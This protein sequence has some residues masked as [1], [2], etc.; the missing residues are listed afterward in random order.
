MS[1]TVTEAATLH[2][3]RVA[4][5]G[6]LATM[7]RAQVIRLVRERGGIWCPSVNRTTTMLVVG[8]EG[9]PLQADGR[10]TTKLQRARSLAKS[11][12]I[13]IVSEGCF[14][15]R[16]GVEAPGGA[17]RRVSLSTLSDLLKVPGQ[18]IR[19]WIE[20]GLVQP[21]ETVEGI[22]HFDFR[23]VSWARTLC[24]CL[25]AGVP[26]AKLRR[27]IEQLRDWLPD[28]DE[29]LTRLAVLEKDGRLMVR[30]QVGLVEPSGQRTLPFEEEEPGGP[31]TVPLAA[32]PQTASEWF[33]VG[34]E[35]E[36]AGD[37]VEAE[38]AYRQ[39]LALGDPEAR[40][41]FNLANVLYA[42]GQKPAAAERYRQAVEL[43]P[44]DADAW[45]NLG[46]VLE[47]LGEREEALAAYQRSLGINPHG[48]EALYNL[49]ELLEQMGR[50][51][52]A[53]GYLEN[54]LRHEPVGLYADYARCQ[55][56]AA[57]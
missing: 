23:Q 10:L 45:N 52:E 15:D 1:D 38:A 35:K 12:R 16:L 39:A 42:Q 11:H 9:W 37:Y 25:Q 5:T 47:E 26:I 2:G 44:A 49:A 19:R 24:D 31:S 48:A 4:I 33:S 57:R 40:T 21:C 41:C 8:Q 53:K 27:S 43:D 30:I 18:R 34:Y 7:P 50:S 3:Q 32:S 46:T 6:R 29:S 28:A 36:T 51:F 17:L 14:F 20:W 22:P 55:L 56:A 13:E 54:L